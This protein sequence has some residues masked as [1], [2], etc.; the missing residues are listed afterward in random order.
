[1][2]LGDKTS[3][4]CVL[5]ERGEIV[6]EGSVGTS[7]K[8]LAQKFGSMRSSRVALEVGT[9]SPWVSRVLKNLGH[10][11]IVA[12]ARQVKLISHSRRKDDRLDA[13]TLARLARVDR[14]CYGR[15]S[16]AAKKRKRT[17]W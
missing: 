2:D 16:T 11:V 12:H 17:C 1:M 6:Q 3:R 14:S 10:P 4:Y 8:A 5:D 13:Q 9:H 7:Q 15:S